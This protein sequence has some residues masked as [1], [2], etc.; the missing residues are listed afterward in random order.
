MT[1]YFRVDAV[2]L[3]RRKL[4][5]D[6]LEKTEV[7]RQISSEVEEFRDGLPRRRRPRAFPHGP[8]TPR[9]PPPRAAG[10]GG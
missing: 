8:R 3:G 5:L 2:G 4:C 6:R 1:L 9:S 10:R 7:L